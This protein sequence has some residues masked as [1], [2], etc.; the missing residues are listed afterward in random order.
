MEINEKYFQNHI[1]E[2]LVNNNS[3]YIERK[4]TDFDLDAMCDREELLRFLRAQ[5]SVWEK[6][7]RKF[8]SE[9]ETLNAVI[10]RYNERLKS[11]S[12]INI[13]NGRDDKAFKIKGVTL[14]LVQYQPQLVTS[15]DEFVRLYSQNHIA[16]VKEF[17]YSTDEKD[18]NN[19]LD[20][21]F[22]ING[23][24]IM[25][26]ELKNEL[27]AT[28]WNYAD[29]INQYKKDRNP[30]NRFLKTCLV[31]FAVDNNYAFMTTRLAGEDTNFLPFNRFTHNPPI[32]G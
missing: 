15:D 16:V 22:L 20:L 30:K 28:H 3:L 24:P 12:I 10:S 13:L 5:K 27:S 4:S 2:Y 18:C 17:K 8:D 26:C 23:L 25:T 14:K 11:E 32:E 1:V 6:L 31:H 9:Q 29:A 19:R 21:V 7:C